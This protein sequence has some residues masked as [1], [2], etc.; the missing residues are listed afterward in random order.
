MKWHSIL[1]LGLILTL[2][3]CSATK[4]IDYKFDVGEV[5]YFKIDNVPMLID[6]RMG[7]KNN[8]QYRV[9]F[10]NESGV[11]QYATVDESEIVLYPQ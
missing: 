2:F 11:L 3:A 5:V 10:K 1:L 4:N 6:K 7:K 8:K 9:V